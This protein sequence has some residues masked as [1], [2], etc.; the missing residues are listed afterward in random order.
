MLVKVTDS[1]LGA[2]A[3]AFENYANVPKLFAIKIGDKR[4]RA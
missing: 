3:A 2:D 1:P 4:S